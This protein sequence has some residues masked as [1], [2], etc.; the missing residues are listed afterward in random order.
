MIKD[1]WSKLIHYNFDTP[2]F[3]GW[4]NTYNLRT[5]MHAF[6]GCTCALDLGAAWR[7]RTSHALAPNLGDTRNR[8]PAGANCA[9]VRVRTRR[10]GGTF[11]SVGRSIFALSTQ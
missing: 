9:R 11:N 5:H 10:H 6:R 3:D 4:M 1:I 7:A 2:I 8:L